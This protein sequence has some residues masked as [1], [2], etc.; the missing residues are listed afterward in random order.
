MKN[1]SIS[2]V[3]AILS[4]TV[5]ITTHA[6]NSQIAME[7]AQNAVT[8]LPLL[9]YKHFSI[10][11]PA[12]GHLIYMNDIPYIE[13]SRGLF[14]TVYIIPS[15]QY[16]LPVKYSTVRFEVD[17][18]LEPDKHYYLDSERTLLSNTVSSVSSP[19]RS[20]ESVHRIESV[21]AIKGGTVIDIEQ[22]FVKNSFRT[23]KIDDVKINIARAREYFVWSQE[24]PNAL[25]GTYKSKN[26][27]HKVT[28][29]ENHFTF[30]IKTKKELGGVFWFDNETI[31][32][33]FDSSKE[34]GNW[35][36]NIRNTEILCYKLNNGVFE[37]TAAK[38]YNFLGTK[39]QYFKNPS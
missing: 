22:S 29:E 37:S 27:K 14:D 5:N 33:S 25:E 31:F 26:G 34:K 18:L 38:R 32:V 30:S 15:G 16:R 39:R 6:Q 9:N 8:C 36:Y 10:L 3:V 2:F 24:N 4:L 20:G 13:Y 21:Y 1:V 23:I 35:H 11:Q 17:A 12:R 19:I 7:K 28:F